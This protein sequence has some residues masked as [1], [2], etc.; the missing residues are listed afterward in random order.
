VV[1][2]GL[3]DVEDAHEG[4][5]DER[6]AADVGVGRAGRAAQLF[7]E[8]GEDE[9]KRVALVAGADVLEAIGVAGAAERGGDL[10]GLAEAADEEGWATEVR[11]L[12]VPGGEGFA[13]DGLDDA[14]LL[15]GDLLGGHD[16]AAKPELGVADLVDRAVEEA[17]VLAFAEDVL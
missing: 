4:G 5:I 6:S 14:G 12:L 10:K 1:A 7:G 9:Q 17:G 3:L 13:V 16:L 11:G 2:G 15:E 8:I